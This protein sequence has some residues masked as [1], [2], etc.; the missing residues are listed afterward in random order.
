MKSKGITKVITVNPGTCV[1]NS[2][3]PFTQKKLM[4]E[5]EEKSGPNSAG[6]ILWPPCI[7]LQIFTAIEQLV[8]EIFQ[9][10]P[11]LWTDRPAASM[12]KN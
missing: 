7:S 2:G 12:A 11:K 9:F 1:Q 3:R 10:G 8:V 5:L 4:E 6:F